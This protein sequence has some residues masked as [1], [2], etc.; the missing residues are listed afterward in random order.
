MTQRRDPRRRCDSYPVA[1]GEH[2]GVEDLWQ[3]MKM[4]HCG[5]SVTVPT[6][7]ATWPRDH[8]RR[9]AVPHGHATPSVVLPHRNRLQ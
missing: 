8:R 6:C 9:A 5:R 4:G 3:E 2:H 7:A 1:R